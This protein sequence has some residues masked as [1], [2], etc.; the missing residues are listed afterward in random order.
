[1]FLF[2]FILLPVLNSMDLSHA[3][4]TTIEKVLNVYFTLE[5]VLKFLLCPHK[6]LFVKD[7]LNFVDFAAILPIYLKMI[8]CE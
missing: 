4:L 8:L 1:M 6:K 3:I 7:V 5:L 2:A